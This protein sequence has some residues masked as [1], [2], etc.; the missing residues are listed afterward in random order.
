MDTEALL[1]DA[2]DLQPAVVELRRLIHRTPELGLQLPRT[3]EVVLDALDGLDLRISTGTAVT[4]VI[5]ELDGDR[6]GPTVL[7]RGD[8]DALPM[9]EDTGIEFAS[10]IAGAMHAWVLVGCGEDVGWRGLDPT[11]GIFAGDDH[12]VL[13]IGR[14]YADVAPIDGVIFASGGQRLEVSVSV[15]PVE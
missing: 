9:P 6:E 5:A 8:M 1:A 10:T 12:V 7:L 11:N 2:A 15:T 14:D 3:Q 13:A 4:S